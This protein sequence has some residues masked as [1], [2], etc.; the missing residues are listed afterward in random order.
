VIDPL[1][2]D[3][4][5]TVKSATIEFAE[6]P[7]GKQQRLANLTEWLDPHWRNEIQNWIEEEV[8]SSF[9]GRQKSRQ[10]EG[11]ELLTPGGT[12]L[13]DFRISG[14]VQNMAQAEV[15]GDEVWQFEAE[16]HIQNFKH[17]LQ[18]TDIPFPRGAS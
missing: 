3:L 9:H 2:G 15:E 13:G 7:S 6:L 10:V 17:L 8:N 12:M 5:F 4:G 11:V 14:P 1:S 18:G 16:I